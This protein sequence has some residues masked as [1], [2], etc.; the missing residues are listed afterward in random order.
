[1][2]DNTSS[3]VGI[4]NGKSSARYH[5]WA[6]PMIG[7]YYNGQSR[8]GCTDTAPCLTSLSLDRTGGDGLITSEI[9]ERGGRP[10]VRWP[11]SADNA[12]LETNTVN[13]YSGTVT[14]ELAY[15]VPIWK[16]QGAAF[17]GEHYYFS[18]ECPEYAGS[19]NADVPY[20]IHWARPGGEPHALTYA[21]PLTQNL[22]WSPSAARLWGVN[23]R[24]NSTT[25]KRVVFSFD[26]PS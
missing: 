26:P 25:G 13:D 11:L 17:D 24:A 19:D 21:P 18:G 7:V 9:N 16:V 20:C 12:L 23:E 4:Q 8:A 6:L 1:M 22:S 14:A 15:R 10:V 3:A 2:S 5:N